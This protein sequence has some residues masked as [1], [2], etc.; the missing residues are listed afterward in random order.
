MVSYL[1]R[2]MHCKLSLSIVPNVQTT[3]LYRIGY[4]SGVTSAITAPVTRGLFSGL[5]VAFSTGAAHKLQKGAIIQDATSIHVV[6]S[7][8]SS[9]SVSTQIATLR[10]LLLG[11]GGGELGAQFK[12]VAEVCGVHYCGSFGL[13]FLN[14]LG[15]AY[16]RSGC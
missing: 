12:K 16:A 15:L 3:S 8:A 6:I 11:A 10:R 4:R 5:A 9:V 2:A 7:M 14:S 1:A 13:L